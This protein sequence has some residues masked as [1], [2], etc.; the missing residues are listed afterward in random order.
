MQETAPPVS[1]SIRDV[2]QWA[3]ESLR[4]LYGKRLQHLILFGSH[5][6]DEALPESDVDLL[7]VLEGPVQS[8]EESRRTSPIA[9]Y[10]AA[11]HGTVLSFVHLSIEDF[12]DERRPLVRT[13][14]KEGI[15]L[16]EA[17][18]PDSSALSQS[19]IEPSTGS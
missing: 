18:I 9:L 1:S 3:T 10:A 4:A 14:H 12:E 6:R 17:P 2:L 7:V 8:L 15:N 11:H 19:S 16:L 13:A 5:A